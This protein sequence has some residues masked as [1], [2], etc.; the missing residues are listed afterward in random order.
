MSVP[1]NGNHRGEHTFQLVCSFSLLHVQFPCKLCCSISLSVIWPQCM[2]LDCCCCAICCVC[3]SRFNRTSQWF[4]NEA[5]KEEEEDETNISRNTT[6]PNRSLARWSC[7]FGQHCNSLYTEYAL[8]RLVIWITV[9]WRKKKKTRYNK[10]G[11][12]QHHTIQMIF[13][14]FGQW[15]AISIVFN[16]LHLKREAS[17]RASNQASQ[18]VRVCGYLICTRASKRSL[19]SRNSRSRT[20]GHVCFLFVDAELLVFCQRLNL[21]VYLLSCCFFFFKLLFCLSL[22]SLLFFIIRLVIVAVA[23]D[24]FFGVWVCISLMFIHF[25][26]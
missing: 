8:S 14:S 9:S 12:D 16:E 20:F 18:R 11:D 4:D 2:Y 13:Y 5:E 15:L 24:G 6:M 3:T 1:L 22:V 7:L 10:D 25:T 17:V 19:W 26:T 21:Y 23:V